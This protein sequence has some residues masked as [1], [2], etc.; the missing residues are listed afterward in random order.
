ML[1]DEIKTPANVR[2]FYEGGPADGCDFSKRHF[3]DRSTM[4]FFGDKMTSFGV[5]RIGGVVYLYRK[6]SAFVNCFGTWRRVAEDI[7]SF[8]NVWRLDPV[9]YDLDC[10][11]KSEIGIFHK[12]YG[13]MRYHNI[14]GVVSYV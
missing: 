8:G 5:S 1:Y 9:T 14:C 11:P 10:V 4:K 2:M 7:Q 12:I 3:F 6:S 13:V